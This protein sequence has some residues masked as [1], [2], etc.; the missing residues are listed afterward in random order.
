MLFIY[1]GSGAS[2]VKLQIFGAEK[3]TPKTS[4]SGVFD[5]SREISTLKDHVHSG[6]YVGNPPT[7]PFPFISQQRRVS[8]P[9][10]IPSLFYFLFFFFS[11]DGV[12]RICGVLFFWEFWVF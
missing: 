3:K 8:Q 11:F 5:F 12:L 7:L 4:K 10:N 9:V 2:K 6:V 1:L